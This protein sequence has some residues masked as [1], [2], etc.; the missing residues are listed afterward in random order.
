LGMSKDWWFYLCEGQIKGGHHPKRTFYL[1]NQLIGSTIG[2]VKR[3][4]MMQWYSHYSISSIACGITLN[5]P[6]WGVESFCEFFAFESF[7]VCCLIEYYIIWKPSVFMDTLRFIVWKKIHLYGY[8]DVHE[9]WDEINRKVA[10][11]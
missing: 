9:P 3:M 7:H 6:K 1:Y 5:V 11:N 10:P 8:N 4:R 2:Y